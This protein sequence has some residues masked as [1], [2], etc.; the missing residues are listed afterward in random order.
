[1]QERLITIEA[2]RLEVVAIFWGALAGLG[3]L[4]FERLSFGL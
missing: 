2:A 4:P 3:I 1:M